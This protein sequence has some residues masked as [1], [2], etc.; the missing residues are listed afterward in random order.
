MYLNTSFAVEIS[1]VDVTLGRS[2]IPLLLSGSGGFAAQP[3]GKHTIFEFY[4]G[5][6]V[7][8]SMSRSLPTIKT[9]GKNVSVVPN[10]KWFR[11]EYS[12]ASCLNRAC[13]FMCDEI[14][15]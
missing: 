2:T 15:K 13:S 7:Y 12:G 6:F 5:F 9:Y 8:E 1:S 11:Q 10:W 14:D 4:Y 3:I